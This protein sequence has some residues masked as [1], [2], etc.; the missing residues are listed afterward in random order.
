MKHLKS[1]IKIIILPNDLNFDKE[2]PYTYRMCGNGIYE[3]SDKE[4][5]DEWKNSHM[6]YY[7][8]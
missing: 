6:D 4:A 1:N 8:Q 7:I 3:I 2:M 5:Y